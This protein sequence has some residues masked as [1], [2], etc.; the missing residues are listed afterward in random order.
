[1]NYA[2]KELSQELYE[3]SGWHDLPDDQVLMDRNNVIVEVRYDLSFLIQQLPESIGHSFFNLHRS[4]PGK[5]TACYLE[6][7]APRVVSDPIER[8]SVVETE[9]ADA[10]VTLA[11]ALIKQGILPAG[12]KYE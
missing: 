5:W 9:A 2:S 11:I 6:Y 4:H 3:L 1:M 12:K 7:S 10:V 8:Y